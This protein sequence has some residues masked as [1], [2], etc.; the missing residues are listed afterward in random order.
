LRKWH[1]NPGEVFAHLTVTPA[2][3]TPKPPSNRK[4]FAKGLFSTA[5]VIFDKFS[6]SCRPVNVRSSP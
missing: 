5:S 2:R 3:K 6:W 4:A 1:G